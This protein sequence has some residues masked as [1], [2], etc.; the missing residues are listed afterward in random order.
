M[1]FAS[2]A[3]RIAIALVVIAVSAVL[4]WFGN[5]LDPW[6]PL[7]W[8]AP[9]PVLLFALHSSWRSA[10]VV[11]ALAWLLGC[12]NMWHYLRL[13][14]VPVVAWLSIFGSVAVIFAAAVLAF[15]ALVRR[16]A[17]WSALLALP[18][19][20]VSLEYIR[21]LTT[22]H[23]T[24]GSLASRSSTSLLSCN[25]LPSPDHGVSVSCCCCFPPHSPSVSICAV[26]SPGKRSAL[27][28]CLSV[29][30]S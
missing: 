25:L 17:P 2:N 10:A 9:L 20:W 22:P 4:V 21:N 11:A 12:F 8:F 29:S 6:W 13:V 30:L 14:G 18:A 1:A 3:R 15:R 27:W 7:L 28:P 26:R 24:A 19:I 16:G 5:G 23:G